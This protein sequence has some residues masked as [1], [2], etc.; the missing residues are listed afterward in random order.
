MSDE[1]NNDEKS[2]VSAEAQ[3]ADQQQAPLGKPTIVTK[4]QVLRMILELTI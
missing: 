2:E 3:S 1:K 4:W